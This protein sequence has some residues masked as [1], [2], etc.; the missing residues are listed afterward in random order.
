MDERREE[1][2]E[3]IRSRVWSGYY[4]PGEVF[5]IVDEDVLGA[6]GEGEQWLRRAVS[7]EFRRKR[8]AERG[9]PTVTS[10]DRLDH[11]FEALRGRG[12]LARHRRGLT[13][14]DGLEVID[15]LYKQAGG[16]KSGLVG[17]CFYHLQDMEGSMWGEGGLWLA[18]GSFPPSRDSA[19]EVGRLVL[20][21]FERAG[22]AVEWD[23]ACDSRLLLKGFRWQ[24]RSPGA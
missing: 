15:E 1:A 13:I 2:L 11:V 20:E 14:Q 12:V 4:D 9:W 23:G 21:E 16:R 7:R 10:C 8:E 19:V 22:F 6:D 18:F 5:D 24:R 17:Y 3:C